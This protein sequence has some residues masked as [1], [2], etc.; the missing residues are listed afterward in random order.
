MYVADDAVD[1]TQTDLDNPVLVHD[2]LT[3]RGG[4][5][6]VVISMLS[7]FPGAPLYTSLYNPTTTYPEF[8]EH[9]VRTM[10]INRVGTIR[11][12]HRLALP[13]LAPSFSRLE[14]DAEVAVCSS[15]GW[16]HGA[17]I[18][19]RKIVYCHNPARWLYQ[20]DVYLGTRPGL[21]K[22]VASRILGGTL[23]RWD[24]R[25]AHT[26]DRYIVNST[27]VQSRVQEIYGIEAEV[28]HPPPPWRV[29]HDQT[30]QGID[31]GYWLCVS[32]LL[33]YKNLHEVLEAFASVP[34]ERLVL[35][36]TGPEEESLRAVC[37]ANVTLLGEVDD[38][39]LAWLYANCR[40]LVSASFE[41]FGLVPLEANVFG[42][43]VAALAWGGHL[44]TVCD[45]LNGYLFDRPQPSAIA[46]AMDRVS[47]SEWSASD[48]MDHA[49]T[50]DENSFVSRLR[51]I[52]AEE[53]SLL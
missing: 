8:S 48:I 41:D 47:R 26:A 49:R 50:F 6:R 29:S 12:N 7:A 21:A 34:S 25:S 24:Q 2:Y 44:D 38:S 42:K 11:R 5:E 13:L 10:G 4:A 35:V 16:A 36:G 23:R 20:R 1:T 46:E 14:I 3:Q 18:S 30:P 51:R 39:S 9:D 27:S 43:P 15:S 32:R 22:G 28:L 37:P 33:P 45:G 40:A 52:V 17:A 53:R 19:G 31:A